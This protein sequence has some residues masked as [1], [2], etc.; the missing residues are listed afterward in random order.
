MLKEGEN[1]IAISSPEAMTLTVRMHGGRTL[2]LCD[3]MVI[4]RHE[5]AICFVV[6]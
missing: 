5:R 6:T 3:V 1:R 4:G 2:G